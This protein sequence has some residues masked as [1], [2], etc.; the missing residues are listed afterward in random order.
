[1]TI[2]TL[3]F[4]NSHQESSVGSGLFLFCK[5][6]LLAC[7]FAIHYVLLQALDGL[8]QQATLQEKLNFETHTLEVQLAEQK[9]H[10]PLM[11]EHAEQ[12]RQQ[13]LPCVT[14]SQPSKA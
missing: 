5:L 12:L 2:L 1:M 13:R 14:S 10:S 3:I 6:G 4:T 11:S 8:K 9:K 7:V